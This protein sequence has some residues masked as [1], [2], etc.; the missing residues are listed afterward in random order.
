M[1]SLLTVLCTKR[2]CEGLA[3]HN[4]GGYI[5]S[6]AYN[7]SLPPLQAALVAAVIG[8]LRELKQVRGWM[9]ALLLGCSVCKIGVC[10]RYVSTEA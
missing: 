9:L 3:L 6:A 4:S 2:E 5:E 8:G 10:W 7:P 1:R